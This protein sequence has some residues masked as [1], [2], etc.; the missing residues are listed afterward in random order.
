MQP[1]NDQT[2]QMT[3]ALI[4]GAHKRFRMKELPDR[5]AVYFHALEDWD[6]EKFK[7]F[8]LY[9]KDR[10]YRIVSLSEYLQPCA[11]GRMLY[12]S[13]D[14]NYLNWYESIGLF[15]SLDMHATFYVN[16]L[17]FMDTC[18]EAARLR[19]FERIG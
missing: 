8:V 16:S 17:P 13:F 12:I 14:D 5:V 3:F 7:R 2:R 1:G 4:R 6:R 11:T 10:G 9:F 18:D 19:Y 15:A